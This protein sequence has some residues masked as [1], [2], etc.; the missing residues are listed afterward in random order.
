MKYQEFLL[1]MFT[2][3]FKKLSADLLNCVLMVKF[4]RSFSYLIMVSQQV[5]HI[6]LL[7]WVNIGNNLKR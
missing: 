1:E 3:I 4:W 2:W 6:Y 7:N 5:A